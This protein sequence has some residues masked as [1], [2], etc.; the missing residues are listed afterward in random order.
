MKISVLGGGPSGLYFAYLARRRLGAVEIDVYERNASDATFGFGVVLAGRGMNNL[1]AADAESFAAIEGL[2]RTLRHQQIVLDGEA[3]HV[4]GQDYGGAIGRLKLLD[5]LQDLCRQSGVRLHHKVEIEDPA[6]LDDADLVVGADGAN[7]M[8]RAAHSEAFGTSAYY[9]TNRFA[10]F[11]AEVES[12]CPSLSFR[13]VPGGAFCAHFYPY[14]ERMCTFVLECDAGAWEGCGFEA[15]DDDERR[16]FC[17][18]L[19]RDELQGQPLISNNS[20][21]RQ[22]RVV[23]NRSWTHGHRVLIGD[24][25]RT[26]HFSI[27]SGTR[28]AM[29][30]AVALVDALAAGGPVAAALDRFV[31]VRRPV[32][33]KL[34]DAARDSFTWYE[35]MA[36]RMAGRTPYDFAYDYLTRT[37]RVDH[38]RLKRDYPGFA[39]AYDS[40]RR[41][42]S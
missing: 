34:T 6:V 33:E 12:D 2:S 18:T 5:R 10:W 28:I 3:V 11:G 26:A 29:E 40:R 13:N 8:L 1:K 19:Y 15:M 38:D 21:W 41:L 24:A 27:G 9:L 16:R 25:V 7:S 17:E 30:D 22:F 35:E 14:A 39:A 37:G 31:A 36:Q 4:E 20:N 42:A 32:A 23:Q